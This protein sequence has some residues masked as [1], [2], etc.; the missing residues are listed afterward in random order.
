MKSNI[1]KSLVLVLFPIL[2]NA[3]VLMET[4]GQKMPDEWID[5]DTKHKIVKLTRDGGSNMSFY[6]HNNPFIGNKMVYYHSNKGN[7]STD[8]KL[9]ISD[10][11]YSNKQIFLL[12]MNTLKSEQLTFQH[13]PMN[14]EIVDAKNGN[15]YYQIKDSVWV[16]NAKT[17]QNKLVFVFPENFKAGITTVNADGTK[18]GGGW[19]D[20]KEK[21]IAKK[22]PQKANTST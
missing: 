11:V 9:E 19:A 2:S 16:V 13:S 7:A 17:K 5:K 6:F 1:L 15:I 12:D 8:Q 21:E 20:D 4:G 10:P 18:L 22:H 14:G 3:Q